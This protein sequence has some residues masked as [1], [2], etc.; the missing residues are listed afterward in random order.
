MSKQAAI[1]YESVLVHLI[2]GELDAFE[3]NH[4]SHPGGSCL[5]ALW[6][7]ELTRRRLGVTY[8]YTYVSRNMAL[9]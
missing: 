6:M 9:Q 2:V 5:R 1:A 8:A 3:A 7:D 4:L